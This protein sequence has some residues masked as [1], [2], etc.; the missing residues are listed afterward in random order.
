[1]AAAKSKS[2]SSEETSTITTKTIPRGSWRSYEP[3]KTISDAFPVVPLDI[4]I[5][6]VFDQL[7]PGGGSAVWSLSAT[8][9][10]GFFVYPL[11]DK[12]CTL[13]S[14]DG[15]RIQASPEVAGIVATLYTLFDRT[16]LAGVRAVEALTQYASQRPDWE[17]IR[18]MWA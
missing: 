15:R 12:T 8:S 5:M 3:Y 9:N 1:M 13:V 16:D 4:H 11:K 6:N 10:G 14:P 17:A 2:Q 7:C 18:S